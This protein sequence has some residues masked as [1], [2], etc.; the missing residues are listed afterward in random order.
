VIRQQDWDDVMLGGGDT[1]EVI[2]AQQ[3]G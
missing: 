1:V 3:G 2:Q